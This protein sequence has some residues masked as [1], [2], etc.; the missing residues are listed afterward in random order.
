MSGT[1]RRLAAD[2]TRANLRCKP[3]ALPVVARGHAS[4][5]LKNVCE[6]AS[7]RQKQAKKRS[8]LAVNEH[9]EPVFNAAMAT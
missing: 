5:P 8:L 3:Q 9:F 4:R 6:A 2:H 7:A 1:A